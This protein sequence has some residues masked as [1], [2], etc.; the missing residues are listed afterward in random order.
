MRELEYTGPVV[1]L[2]HLAGDGRAHVLA[3]YGGRD[4]V[5]NPRVRV[6]AR[7]FSDE[8]GEGMVAGEGA[9]DDYF[10]VVGAFLDAK[11]VHTIPDFKREASVDF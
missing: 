9:A 5:L 11:R 6:W 10:A 1:G 7:R 2:E 8:E 3:G 4:G